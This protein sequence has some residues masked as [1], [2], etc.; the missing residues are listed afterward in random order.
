M[1]NMNGTTISVI[2]YWVIARVEECY[3]FELMVLNVFR[4]CWIFFSINADIILRVTGDR[5]LSL[6]PV[7][8][9]F[10]SSCPA[11]CDRGFS[12]V[13]LNRSA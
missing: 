6:L 11:A 7:I 5:F 9:Y 2:F 13:M 1:D 8:R 3:I 10:I 4:F 12:S